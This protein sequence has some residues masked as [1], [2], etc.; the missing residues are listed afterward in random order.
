MSSLAFLPREADLEIMRK[1]NLTKKSWITIRTINRRF[2]LRLR[3]IMNPNYLDFK[4]INLLILI[5]K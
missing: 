2:I 5:K 4:E 3:K 1:L